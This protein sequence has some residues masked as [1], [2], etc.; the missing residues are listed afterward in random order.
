MA[1]ND[2]VQFPWNQKQLEELDAELAKVMEMLSATY[3]QFTNAVKPLAERD[4]SIGVSAGNVQ[5]KI[6]EASLW[7]STIIPRVAQHVQAVTEAMQDQK[8][9]ANG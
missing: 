2:V 8:G 4:P 6:Q 9:G 5:N 7:V 1:K 3:E